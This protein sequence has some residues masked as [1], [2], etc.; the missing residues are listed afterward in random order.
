MPTV[1]EGFPPTL[2]RQ[3]AHEDT[4]EE[5]TV[6][7]QAGR[8]QQDIYRKGKPQGM[9]T[10]LFPPP[11]A[12]NRG[13][14]QA[15]LQTH[16]NAFHLE[17]LITLSRK[18]ATISGDSITKEEKELIQYITSVHNNANKGIKGRGKGRKVKRIVLA[19]PYQQQQQ[20]PHQTS[21]MPTTTSPANSSPIHPYSMVL[22]PHG[23]PQLHTSPPPQQQQPMH[24]FHHSGLSSSPTAYSS[25]SSMGRSPPHHSHNHNHNH[26]MLFGSNMGDAQGYGMMHDS[27]AT[28]PAGSSSSSNSSQVSTPVHDMHHHHQQ[29]LHHLHH[30]HQQQQQQMY[31][32][33]HERGLVF[34]DRLY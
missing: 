12:C 1:W 29:Q 30:Q 33:E 14:T 3:V 13:L 20:Q 24:P 22:L 26:N 17:T 8:L 10:P 19:Q 9:P 2:Q 34:A 4:R 21:P 23:L 18:F 7:V 25:S 5:G 11:V 16:Q 6:F 32:E 31:D 28:S 15:G 27:D